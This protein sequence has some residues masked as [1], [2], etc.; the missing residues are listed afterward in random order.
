MFF[1]VRD[2]IYVSVM[3]CM[4]DCGIRSVLGWWRIVVWLVVLEVCSGGD[5]SSIIMCNC[6]ERSVL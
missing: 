1:V 2:L 3:L 6:K 4:F 5:V